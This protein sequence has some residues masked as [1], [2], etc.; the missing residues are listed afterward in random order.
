MAAHGPQVDGCEGEAQQRK[1]A[2]AQVCSREKIER[3]GNLYTASGEGA[4]AV[5]KYIAGMRGWKRAVG[6]K[7]DGL[8]VRYLDLFEGDDVVT[9]Q[10]TKWV[11]ASAGIPGWDG[12]SDL[13]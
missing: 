5:R 7:P 12:V 11:K 8:I 1:G 9:P 13:C 6:Q 10:L 4:E 3:G 2:E